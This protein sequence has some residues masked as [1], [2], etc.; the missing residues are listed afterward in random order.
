MWITRPP[1]SHIHRRRLLVKN[2]SKTK[3]FFHEIKRDP[4]EVGLFPKSNEAESLH[5]LIVVTVS[6][7]IA[8]PT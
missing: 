7:S 8:R 5:N 4:H 3:A 1:L 6:L 2:Y